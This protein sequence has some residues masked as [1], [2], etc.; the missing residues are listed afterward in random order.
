M[1]QLEN[2]IFKENR[3]QIIMFENLNLK[4]TMFKFNIKFLTTTKKLI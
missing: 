4:L 1:I 3:Q 2:L